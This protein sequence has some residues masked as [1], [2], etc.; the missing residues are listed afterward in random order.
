VRL[1]NLLAEL[2]VRCTV[3]L[4]THIVEDISQSCSDLAVIDAGKV[5]FHGDPSML[6]DQARGK[7]WTITSDA[8]KP[9]SDVLVVST[10]H[11]R[12]GTQYRMIGAA[13]AMVAAVPVEPSLEDGY[14][15]L[16]R[17]KQDDRRFL[18]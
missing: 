11:L 12:N 9:P 16:M 3:I 4:S 7:V 6:I 1:R 8:E 14:L 13:P 10:M 2:S 18:N 15:W 5:L 17:Q